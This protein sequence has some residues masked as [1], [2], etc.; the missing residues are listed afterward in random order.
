MNIEHVAADDKTFLAEIIWD[1]G[2]LLKL[3]MQEKRSHSM[4][5]VRV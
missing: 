2:T 5:N 4:W 3:K 1:L